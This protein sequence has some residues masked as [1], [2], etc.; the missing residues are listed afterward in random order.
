[1]PADTARRKPPYRLI[2]S[3]CFGVPA[4]AKTLIEALVRAKR[5]A[6]RHGV[7]YDVCRVNEAGRYWTIERI[8]PDV[9][10]KK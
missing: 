4:M 9:P 1:M 8:N 3:S 5:L 6:N 2:P 7:R 10:G